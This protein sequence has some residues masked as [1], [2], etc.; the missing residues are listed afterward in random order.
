VVCPWSVWASRSPSPAARTDPGAR[1]AT[2]R[3]RQPHPSIQT[4]CA[5]LFSWRHPSSPSVR[6][7]C[8]AASSFSVTL[9]L[10]AARAHQ[11]SVV[12][13]SYPSPSSPQQRVRSLL[14]GSR[15]NALLCRRPL[16]RAG[17]AQ[18]ASFRRH[19]STSSVQRPACWRTPK[20]GSS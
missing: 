5:S 1:V 8:H 9:G 10:L 15:A 14:Q 16:C 11:R 7:V 6:R 20:G 4:R 3:H 13:I 12:T 17:P 19:S 2:G 18:H